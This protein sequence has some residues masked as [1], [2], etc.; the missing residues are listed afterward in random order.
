MNAKEM[1]ASVQGLVQATDAKQNVE[2]LLEVFPA[3]AKKVTVWFV[4][5]YAEVCLSKG[6]SFCLVII[7]PKITVFNVFCCL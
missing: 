6:L 4:G 5:Q 2:T 1:S 7:R 3:R